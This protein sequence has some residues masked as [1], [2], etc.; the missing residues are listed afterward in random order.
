MLKRF[1]LQFV[2]RF[3]KKKKKMQV[4]VQGTY[5]KKKRIEKNGSNHLILIKY[6]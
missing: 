5:N 4:E 3:N 2:D 1:C 6:Q